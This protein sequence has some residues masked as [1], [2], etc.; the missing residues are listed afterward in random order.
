MAGETEQSS[1]A[2]TDEG[3]AQRWQVEFAAA[4]KA[5]EAW[6]KQG[7]EIDKEYRDE[8]SG[9]GK[10]ETK[11]NLYTSTTQTI[12]AVLFGNTPK[13]DVGRRFADADDDIGRVAGELME[14]NL[15]ADFEISD[16]SDVAALQYTLQ[17]RMGPGAGCARVRY[18]MEEEKVPAVPAM[19]HPETGAVLAPEVPETTQ[20]SSESVETDYVHWQDM[21]WS[22]ARVWHEVRWVAFRAPMTKEQLTSRFGEEMANAVPLVSKSDRN[23]SD[24]DRD[25]LDPWARADVWEIWHKE[26]PAEEEEGTVAAEEA[27]GEVFWYVDGY[28]KVL[29]RKVDPLG[30]EG[31]WPCPRPMFANLTTSKL[32]P[33]PD[34]VLSQ[35]LYSEVNRI[36]TRIE[37]LQRAIKAVGLYDA[38]Q[39][40]LMR[41]LDEGVQ[42]QMLPAKNWGAF[43]ENGG[44]AGGF[45]F[46]PLDTLVNALTQLRDY[47]HE[48][49]DMLY[50]QTGQA[51]IMRGMSSTAG[52]SATEQAIKTRFGAARIDRLQKEFARFATDIQKLKAEIISKH[53]SPKTILERANSQFAFTQEDQQ[54]LPQAVELLKSQLGCYRIE[55][56]SETV[57]MQDMGALKA[58]RTEV[59]ASI[60]QFFM[61]AQPLA[62]SMPSAM[63]FLLKMLQAL[64]ATVRGGA[65]MEGIL[66]SAIAQM[67]QQQAASA[68]QPKQPP[69]PDPKLQIQQMK[70]QGDQQK[71]QADMQKEQFKLQADLQRQSAETQAHAQ[72]EQD[73]MRSNVEEAAK[74][75]LVAHS[76]KAAVPVL[77]GGNGGL[78]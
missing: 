19:R 18:E 51:D 46:L 75:A 62:Q 17:D 65:Q 45:Q 7:Q 54:H 66:D 76:L 59:M 40:D 20:K 36:S 30:L 77:P 67:E 63:P 41:L 73:Q 14:R 8:R 23:D 21:L 22:P 52:T 10:D 4:K 55:V 53:F 32:V 47:R 25:S 60:S 64:L 15:N 72:Q 44:I 49:V 2:N 39:P 33:R 37:A 68:G 58:E 35:D 29:D 26:P 16:S 27:Q 42:N 11:W 9:T 6:H 70:M 56:K 12:E 71:A 28:G 50:Q 24:K 69:P 5:L 13:V 43:M 1:F 78:P 74:K 31:F 48:L 38:S 34:Y 61:A 57:S 3:W